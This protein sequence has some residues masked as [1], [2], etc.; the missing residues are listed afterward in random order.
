VNSLKD[1]CQ[2]LRLGDVSLDVLHNLDV[3]QPEQCIK[4]APTTADN[5]DGAT[6]KRM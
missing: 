1:W 5:V 2:D 4:S 3:R 6:A